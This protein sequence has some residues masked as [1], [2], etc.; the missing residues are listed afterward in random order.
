MRIEST[1]MMSNP[2]ES[3][4]T[5][6]IHEQ[7]VA[8][9][10]VEA[11]FTQKPSTTVKVFIIV[12]SLILGLM[13]L[14]ALIWCLWKAGFFKREFKKKK[15]EEEFNRDSWDYVPKHDKRESTS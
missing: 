3:P 8:E 11:V 7:P 2:R 14:A 13:I 5:I 10:V 1:A 9:V 15:E 6:L 12:I 4:H